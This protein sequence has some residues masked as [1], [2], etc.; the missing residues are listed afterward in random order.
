ME[1]TSTN[2]KGGTTG[3]RYETGLRGVKKQRS[4]VRLLPQHR[5]SALRST[6]RLDRRSGR[7]RRRSHTRAL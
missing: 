7:G 2:M 6:N 3:Y 5:L 1:M 4:D